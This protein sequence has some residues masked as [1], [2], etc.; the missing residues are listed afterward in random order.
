MQA[1]FVGAVVGVFGSDG[2][3]LLVRP[4]VAFLTTL[5]HKV[6]RRRGDI[7]VAVLDE[8]THVAE[9]EGENQGGNVASVHIGIGHDDDLVVTEFL[10]IEGVAVLRRADGDTQCRIDVLDFLTV[11][12]AMFGSLLHIQ[13]LTTE[14]E[15]GLEVA[16]TALLG[17]S[18]CGVTLHEVEFALFRHLRRAVGKLAGEAAA[19][20][21]GLA[22]H[23]LT[24]L[25][26]GM[27]RRGRQNHLAH[28][29]LRIPRMLL[30]VVF[31]HVAHRL[32]DNAL[33]LAV[34][35]LGLGLSLKLRFRH[36]HGD[37]G[38]KSLTEVVARNLDLVLLEFVEHLVVAGIALQGVGEGTAETG[39]V[40]ATLY[41]IDI[42]DI[43]MDILVPAVV[44]LHHHLNRNPALF[45]FNI[46]RSLHNLGAAAV[47]EAD[48]VLQ[49]L[50]GIEGLALELPVVLLFAA[51]GE[52]DTDFLVQEGQFL[53]TARQNV[54]LVFGHIENAVIGG[55]GD[56]RSAVVGRAVLFHRVEG[57]SVCK[58]LHIM[59]TVTVNI[60]TEVFGKG[61]DA[62]YT[63]AMQTA[64][65]LV[66]ILVELTA[67]MQHSKN[68][69]QSGTVLLFVHIGRNTTTVI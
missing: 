8:G 36:F 47:E 33:N 52:L 51:V 53:Q 49:A 14:R 15:D 41:R 32:T 61:I 46:D 26:G 28:N 59:L 54:I 45:G 1:A 9:E 64:R 55:E 58:L 19:A 7:N 42:V 35:Q 4:C 56:F 6:E 16:V 2:V 68:D 31:E 57:L 44:V 69:L 29:L 40:R 66:G 62:G 38:G 39:E 25:A 22:L 60:G 20:E 24:G 43:R 12:D 17:G 48:E 18:A 3:A 27:T 50:F 21:G 63:H 23:L 30:K 37:D 67:R 13:D 5:L 11:E 65:D 10:K 34:T